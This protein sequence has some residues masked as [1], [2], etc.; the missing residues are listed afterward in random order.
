M[1]VPIGLL[2]AML[3]LSQPELSVVR[4]EDA[5]SFVLVGEPTYP[6]EITF[7]FRGKD[8]PLSRFINAAD[9]LYG[10]DTIMTDHQ[11]DL[12]RD[13]FKECLEICKKVVRFMKTGVQ[14]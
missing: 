7:S 11:R 14:P 1:S 2:F 9:A 10:G 4:V 3:A 5:D 12:T 13:E 8:C 6:Q